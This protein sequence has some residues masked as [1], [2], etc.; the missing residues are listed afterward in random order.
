MHWYVNIIKDLQDPIIDDANTLKTPEA[1]RIWKEQRKVVRCCFNFF[2]F[3][4]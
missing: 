2:P 3:D 1:S 4:C